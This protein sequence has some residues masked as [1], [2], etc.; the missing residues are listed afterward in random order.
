[1]KA[2]FFLILLANVAVLMWEYK[3]GAL[4]SRENQVEI[5]SNLETI[6]LTNESLPVV[7]GQIQPEQTITA[8]AP[9]QDAQQ[10][11]SETTGQRP[12]APAPQALVETEIAGNLQAPSQHPEN[13]VAAANDAPSQDLCFEAGPFA[14]EADYQT[15]LKQL[16]VAS[17]NL[18][19]VY[20]EGRVISS[21]LV[22][23]P[24]GDTDEQAKD[25]I[26][27]LKDKGI[28]DLWL[29]RNGEDKGLI[30][31][32][33]FKGEARAQVMKDELK[34]QKGID[35]LVKPKSVPGKVKYAQIKINAAD[36]DRLK[37]HASGELN[38]S[39]IDCW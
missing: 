8:D 30:S 11:S 28:S 24:G 2:L 38:W 39:Q 34:Q 18:K 29:I 3:T 32:A 26:K 19:P 31:L 1:M 36:S 9:G 6:R 37:S 15:W 10:A 16:P 14:A 20:K 22:Y 12:N 35:A 7:S 23:F 27:M 21:Y 4:V 17:P 25:N 33:L 13:P 5:S